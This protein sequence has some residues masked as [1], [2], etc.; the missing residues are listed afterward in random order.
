MGTNNSTLTN[1]LCCC[2]FYLILQ[3]PL[4]F[5]EWRSWESCKN[6]CESAV[7]DS[8]NLTKGDVSVYTYIDLILAENDARIC[9][10]APASLPLHY[11]K[12][13]L[14]LKAWISLRHLFGQCLTLAWSSQIQVLGVTVGSSTS[15]ASRWWQ[16]D[17]SPCCAVEETECVPWDRRKDGRTRR[18][19][20]VGTD[21]W[22]SNSEKRVWFFAVIWITNE[23]KTFNRWN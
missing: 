21:C 12:P 11:T 9:S 20:N 10:L 22:G 3:L 7:I 23:T 1:F 19:K 6:L 2:Y 5:E 17:L 16:M 4:I 18:Q 8:C 15:S 13:L 14:S